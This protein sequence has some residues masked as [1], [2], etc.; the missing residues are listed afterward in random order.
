M[1]APGF[2]HLWRGRIINKLKT[3]GNDRLRTERREERGERR[4][5]K[6]RVREKLVGRGAQEKQEPHT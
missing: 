5:E 6:M 1:T 4:E 3:L 2:F